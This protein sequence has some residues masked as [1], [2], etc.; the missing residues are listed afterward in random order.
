[1]ADSAMPPRAA[2]R[3][4][5]RGAHRCDCQLA[6]CD[7]DAEWR[8]ELQQ[9]A[10]QHVQRAD[11]V[12]GDQLG[13]DARGALRVEEVRIGE[14]L[15]PAK[16]KV[17]PR[18]ARSGSSAHE[19]IALA[20]GGGDQNTQRAGR[21]MTVLVF[22]LPGRVLTGFELTVRTGRLRCDISPV[23]RTGAERPLKHRV[24]R[25]SSSTTG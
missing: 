17:K 23:W 5:S 24:H 2:M 15:E 6:E 3:V 11:A 4:H 21:F 20:W 18:N 1:M 25:A 12:G 9:V 7:D 16:Q 14:L 22:G 8:G 13:L 10:E 19:A